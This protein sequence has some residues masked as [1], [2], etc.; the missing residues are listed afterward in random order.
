MITDH[1][2]IKCWNLKIVK[3]F[4]LDFLLK[5][6]NILDVLLS[7]NFFLVIFLFC[8]QFTS[9]VWTTLMSLDFLIDLIL[10]ATLALG[11]TWP[12]NR[13]EC[14]EYSLG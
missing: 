13:S 14:Q 8:E 11:S 5:F 4:F 2:N 1:F 3:S 6:I 12:R 7:C 10:T 9:V